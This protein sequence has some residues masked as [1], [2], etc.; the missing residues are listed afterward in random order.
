MLT[1]V[2]FHHA[3][4]CRDVQVLER[5]FFGTDDPHLSP[6][7]CGTVLRALPL[8]TV[9]LAKRRFG[10]EEVKEVGRRWAGSYEALSFVTNRHRTPMCFVCGMPCC[11]ARPFSQSPVPATPVQAPCFVSTAA[12]LTVP[13]T[14]H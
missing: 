7:E 12:V 5:L 9:K 2:P 14:F 8:S 1:H 6:F 10:K 4:R 11:A 3:L 13:P